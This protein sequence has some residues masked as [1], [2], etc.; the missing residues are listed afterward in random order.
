MTP[1]QARKLKVGDTVKFPE[2]RGEPAGSGRV[3]HVSDMEPALNIKGT[4]YIWVTVAALNKR[5]VWPSN[6][7]SK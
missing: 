3:T 6:K 1:E 2:D 4:P 7:I 5:S